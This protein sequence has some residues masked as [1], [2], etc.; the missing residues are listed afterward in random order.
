[1][2]T[3]NLK[4]SVYLPKMACN[5][6]GES[7]NCQNGF[8]LVEL[9]V[10]L[11]IVG[12]IS[13]L[14]ASPYFGF[15]RLFLNQFTAVDVASQNRLALDEIVNQIR[16]SETVLSSSTI[17]DGY[18]S[19]LDSLVLSLWPLDENSKPYQYTTYKDQIIYQRNPSDNSKL[20]KITCTQPGLSSRNRGTETISSDI[21]KLEFNFDRVPPNTNIVT[22]TVGNTRIY[23]NKT[24]T[25]VQ[26]ADAAL[27]NK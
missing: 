27:R 22:V 16:Q 2:L 13:V 15:F 8:T 20:I 17:C 7:V 25:V 5:K 18:F 21:S 3:E 4:W 19:S 23:D 1:M 26:S 9:I 24:H 11:G 10:G 12:I 6:Q 14:I